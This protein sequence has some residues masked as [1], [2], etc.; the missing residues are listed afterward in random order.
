MTI[1]LDQ[2]YPP[3][4]TVDYTDA[5]ITDFDQEGQITAVYA[6][7]TKLTE[8]YVD[9]SGT[10][11]DSAWDPTTSLDVED[12]QPFVIPHTIGEIKTDSSG[13]D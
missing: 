6:L 3:S 9:E 7:G 13:N 12:S 2:N 1:T 4:I 8:K 10:Q 5:S 11:I